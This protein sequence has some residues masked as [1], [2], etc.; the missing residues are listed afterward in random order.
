M[1]KWSLANLR[2]GTKILALA[3]LLL[4]IF[5]S[6]LVYGILSSRS[7]DQIYKSS[8]T[9]SVPF[10]IDTLRVDR[11][12]WQMEAEAR[13]Q[14]LDGQ[15]RTYAAALMKLKSDLAAAARL[16][17]PGKERQSFA[18]MRKA[19]LASVALTEREDAL[20]RAGHAKQAVKLMES[21]A[22]IRSQADAAIQSVL[23]MESQRNAQ[24]TQRN[25][26]SASRTQLVQL[27]L[28]ILAALLAA[29][30]GVAISRAIVGPLSR[31]VAVLERVADGD[32]TVPPLP[33]TGRDEVASLS[34]ASNKMLQAL[35]GVIGSIH[36]MS[37]QVNS[38]SRQLTEAAGQ[39]ATVAQQ[40]SVA[41]TQVAQGAVQQ[42]AHASGGAQAMQELRQAVDQIAKG[43]QAQALETEQASD[44]MGE[45][46]RQVSAMVQ[47]V[48]A[49]AGHADLTL[50]AAES[51]G[52]AIGE[53][54]KAMAEIHTSVFNATEK[55]GR[56]GESSRQIDEIIQVI[57]DIAGQTNLLALNA[58]IEAARAGDHGRGFAVVAEE[59]RALADRVKT[60]AMEIESLIRGMQQETHEALAATQEGAREVERGK[61]LGDRAGAALR[62]ILEATGQTSQQV[63]QVTEAGRR[64]VETA[65]QA[66]ER[67]VSVSSI[68]EENS[69]SAEEMAASSGQVVDAVS[70]VAA[71]SQETGASAE[72]VSASVEE[73]SAS[74][75]EIAASADGLSRLA[76]ELRD[77]VARFKV[78]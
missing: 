7:V 64:V 19:V 61:A 42:A 27:I 21:S 39:T 67:M 45:A 56:L 60:A 1:G 30:L 63:R 69:A 59:V 24:A 4:V 33:V 3:G 77:A 70:Q 35:Q 8:L 66:A 51:G 52:Q 58:A 18:A 13:G 28:V 22:G 31:A 14:L 10:Q 37:E 55:V 62:E 32:L 25:D 65:K 11:S 46:S 72:E 78:A 26:A 38:A 20:A 17:P 71:I 29:F 15:S 5:V 36:R 49:V 76:G 40:V 57:S 47:D 16:V 34:R 74:A 73:M 2:I 54:V 9:V 50:Q 53:A 44:L 41:V 12:L 43:A 6:V 23:N 75:E 48:D 68:T